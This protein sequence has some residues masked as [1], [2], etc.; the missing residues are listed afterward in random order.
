MINLRVI[1]LSLINLSLI[2]LSLINLRGTSK[3]SDL[4]IHSHGRI[5]ITVGGTAAHRKPDDYV[6]IDWEKF[7][8]SRCPI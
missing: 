3:N 8:F 1:H 2:N 5:R 7:N 6:G 4:S